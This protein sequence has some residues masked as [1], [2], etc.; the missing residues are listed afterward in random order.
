MHGTSDDS[1]A[2][3]YRMMKDV[4]TLPSEDVCKLVRKAQNG[5]TAARN[6]LMKHNLKLVLAMAFRQAGKNSNVPMEDRIQFGNIGLVRA[7]EKYDPD[8]INPDTNKPYAFSTYAT[9]W[10]K[11]SIDREC[12]NSS[13]TIRIPIHMLK[14]YGAYMR[15]KKILNTKGIHKPAEEDFYPYLDDEPLLNKENLHKCMTQMP[16]VRSDRIFDD[17]DHE[18][19]LFDSILDEDSDLASQF[20]TA[21]LGEFINEKLSVL[22]ERHRM[23]LELRFGINSER[24]FTLEEVATM[25]GC[26]RERV[27]QI[28]VIALK[29][30]KAAL[31]KENLDL[32]TLL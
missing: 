1:L 7:I 2:H 28:Q 5:D 11:Q 24:T 6:M 19:S 32:E 13:S 15:I 9:W 31:V 30:L 26:T 20:E 25:I 4:S 29:S 17:S 21:D 3:Y 14:A 18:T 8:K 12:M 22:P 16:S 27:R 10:I 23:I